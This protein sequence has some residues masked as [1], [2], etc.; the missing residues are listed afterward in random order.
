MSAVGSVRDTMSATLT[1]A[2]FSEGSTPQSVLVRDAPCDEQVVLLC[3]DHR[4]NGTMPLIVLVMIKVTECCGTARRRARPSR[5]R[6]VWRWSAP[7][8]HRIEESLRDTSASVI[9]PT[10]TAQIRC[11]G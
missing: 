3:R 1:R 11:P 6:P 2:F 7:V 9:H 10:G 4:Q 5:R 8:P